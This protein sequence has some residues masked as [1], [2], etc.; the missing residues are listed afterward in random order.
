MK[1]NLLKLNVVLLAFL[2]VIAAKGQTFGHN[3]ANELNKKYN[4]LFT[5][6]NTFE[7]VA[8]AYNEWKSVVLTMKTFIEDNSKNMFRI[9]DSTIINYLNQL[10]KAHQ[11]VAT[12][13]QQYRNKNLAPHVALYKSNL[14]GWAKEIARINNAMQIETSFNKLLASDKQE[15]KADAIIVLKELAQKMLEVIEKLR[16]TL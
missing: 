8:G 5:N 2:L 16:A 13:I 15:K 10:L 6:K 12:I 3:V 1:S 11:A 7:S 4:N 14:G 9:K